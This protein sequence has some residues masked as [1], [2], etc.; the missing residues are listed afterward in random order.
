MHDIPHSFFNYYTYTVKDKLAQ[1]IT[2]E[3]DMLKFTDLEKKISKM[4]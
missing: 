3:D 1:E 4:A 2:V